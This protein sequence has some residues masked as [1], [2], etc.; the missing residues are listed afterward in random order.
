[1]VI[2]TAAF[3]ALQYPRAQRIILD[4]DGLAAPTIAADDSSPPSEDSAANRLERFERQQRFLAIADRVERVC[5]E[6]G[7]GREAFRQ[8]FGT[9]RIP[10]TP[11]VLANLGVDD[12]LIFPRDGRMTDRGRIKELLR[13]ILDDGFG[14]DPRDAGE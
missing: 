1:M 10:D 13:P 2:F 4:Y 8:T 3:F 14:L 5:R 7:I 11:D 6:Y 9:I 12:L